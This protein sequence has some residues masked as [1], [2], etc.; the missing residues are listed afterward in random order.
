MRRRLLSAV[1]QIVPTLCTTTA[2]LPVQ[3][4]ACS[5]RLGC[6]WCRGVIRI[7]D[8]GV[9]KRV[10]NEDYTSQWIEA[11]GI[12]T[13]IRIRFVQGCTPFS[14]TPIPSSDLYVSLT[15]SPQPLQAQWKSLLGWPLR[16]ERLQGNHQHIIE[17]ERS[18]NPSKTQSSYQSGMAIVFD[19]TTC[20]LS[21]ART[22]TNS[23][24]RPLM[25]AKCSATTRE[26]IGNDMRDWQA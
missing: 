22:S 26:L 18:A 23:P 2:L 12:E 10:S 14:R 3:S 5:Y 24:L 8:Q 19:L 25:Y 11:T 20:S 21:G 17:L 13:R 6:I 16:H 1:D 7:L 4:A 9:S 15:Q